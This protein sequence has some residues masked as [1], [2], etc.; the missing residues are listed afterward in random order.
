V[1]V[2][3]TPDEK[4]GE[5]PTAIVYGSDDLS[6]ERISEAIEGRLARYKRPK[7]IVI[8]SQPLP[9]MASGKIARRI[10]RDGF[11]SVVTD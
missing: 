7:K 1:C 4:F 10:V 11:N 6:P 3:A 8:S 9:R 2:I 5:A